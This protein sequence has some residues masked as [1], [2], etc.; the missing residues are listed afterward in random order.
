MCTSK[1]WSKETISP[2][3]QQEVMCN[4]QEVMWISRRL[5]DNQQGVMWR[6][7]L[8]TSCRPAPL[9]SGN[10]VTSPYLNGQ[11]SIRTSISQFRRL[12]IVV[13]VHLELEST[14]NICKTWW[15]MVKNKVPYSKLKPPYSI[16][17]RPYPKLWRQF[18]NGWQRE[19]A[20]KFWEEAPKLGIGT[21]KFGLGTP[22][23][24]LGCCGS[25]E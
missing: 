23:F 5:C 14:R 3:N 20:P 6:K 9:G 8:K 21:H 24:A 17:R 2:C 13:N 25:L 10:Y 12:G 19:L 18:Q 4:Q 11:F 1:F 7:K 15:Q 22:K 16:I